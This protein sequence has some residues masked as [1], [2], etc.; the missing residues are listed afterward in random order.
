MKKILRIC[1]LNLYKLYILIRCFGKRKRRVYFFHIP[2]NS[3]MGDQAIIYTEKMFVKKYLSNCK[4]IEIPYYLEDRDFNFLVHLI[5]PT[6]LILIQGG[7]SLGDLYPKEDL[8]TQNII[9]TFVN[10][11]III[12]PQTI[13]YR[14]SE[15]SEQLK[16]MAIDTFSKHP[17]LV[18]CA[19]EKISY[20]I[21]CKLFPKNKI[22]LVPDMVFSFNYSKQY[23]RKPE[24]LFLLRNDFEKRIS[25]NEMNSLIQKIEQKNIPYCIYDTFL[26]DYFLIKKTYPFLRKKRLFQLLK[27]CAQ[28]Q[29][30]ITDRLHGMIFSFLTH[31]PCYVFENIN[32]KIRGVHAW[33]SDTNAIELVST[34]EEVDFQILNQKHI[35]TS[36]Q[37]LNRQFQKLVKEMDIE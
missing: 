33:I 17:N 6:D 3:N 13:T 28:S 21:M 16:K 1:K 24:I 9:K 36:Q 27:K 31:T 26:D 30:I 29:L 23:T 32:H 18:I 37:K 8:R 7:G 25:D 4:R 34:A 14:N 35:W 15:K 20:D 11:K 5:K 19:R 22:L 10:N 12:M 2:V